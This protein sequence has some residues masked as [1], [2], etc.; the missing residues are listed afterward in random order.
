[1][2]RTD[3]LSHEERLRQLAEKRAVVRVD[4]QPV[5]EREGIAW[6]GGTNEQPLGVR[7]TFENPWPHPTQR[8][9]AAVR[10]AEYGVFLPWQPFA[11]VEVPP[12][13]PGGR[14]VVTAAA[15]L[16]PPRRPA[17]ASVVA[18]AM[19]RIVSETF[20]LDLR[21]LGPALRFA[22]NIDVRVG[23]QDPVE[24]HF[25]AFRCLHPGH[26]NVAMFKVG[27]R[28]REE[29]IVRLAEAP[30]SW[31]VGLLLPRIGLRAGREELEDG[32]EVTMA[33]DTALALVTPPDYQAEGKVAFE[34]ARPAT[35]QHATVELELV[36]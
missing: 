11:T 7:L 36:A 15:P 26:T 10:Y 18:L 34:F 20:D 25:G 2:S 1:M 19:G 35:G 4:R 8:T 6:M 5:I 22:A 31:N 12:I 30:L 17:M 14:Q 33:A 21:E 28:E 16:P 9:Q 32:V 3:V 13:P 24:K 29:H 27:G 23:A